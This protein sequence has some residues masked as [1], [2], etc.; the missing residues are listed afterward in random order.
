MLALPAQDQD[1]YQHAL[2]KGR[3]N[4]EETKTSMSARSPKLFTTQIYCCSNKIRVKQ[5]NNT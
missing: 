2:G 4:L 1:L 5:K 3:K